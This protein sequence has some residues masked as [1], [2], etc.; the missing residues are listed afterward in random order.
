MM[1][2]CNHIFLILK[3]TSLSP[4]SA[5][6]RLVV[7]W[8]Y[9][10][11]FSRCFSWLPT[12]VRLLLYWFPVDVVG[13]VVVA[14]GFA[15]LD[16]ADFA[17]LGFVGLDSVGLDFAHDQAN[18]W[19]CFFQCGHL[20]VAVVVVELFLLLLLCAYLLKSIISAE[21]PKLSPVS[22]PWFY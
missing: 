12:Y 19:H 6:F 8:L 7:V 9:R 1:C 15:G 20:V 18:C 14:V 2:K 22:P 13:F 3:F 21:V 4:S 17:G 11:F 16:F 5:V 10:G